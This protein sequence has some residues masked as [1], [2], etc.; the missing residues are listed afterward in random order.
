MIRIQVPPLR[1]RREDI[2]ALVRHFAQKLAG[3]EGQAMPVVLSEALEALSTY[4]FPGNV[5]ELQ[6]MVERAVA[7]S[8]G[9]PI[10]PELF[11]ENMRTG[12]DL[13]GADY[14]EIPEDG[15][16]LDGVLASVERK[17]LSLALQRAGGVKKEAARLLRI[18]FRSI[19][20]RLL[21]H[22]LD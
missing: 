19:R 9:R 5:R 20:Y 8:G 16:D 6:N 18:S 10:G 13:A 11:L 2:P 3:E 21:K 22:G 14:G 4:E 17:L 15:L 1:D 7:L 12:D